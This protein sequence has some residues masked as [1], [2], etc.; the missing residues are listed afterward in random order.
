MYRNLLAL[1]ALIA[2]QAVALHAHAVTMCAAGNPDT[3]SV[4]EL[5]PT[6]AF[7]NHNDGTVTHS[8]TGLMWKQC[9]EGSSGAGCA[10]GAPAIMTWSAA[11]A[12]AVAD[13]TAGHSDW[14]LPNKKELES[15]VESCGFS[16][17]INQT[18]FPATPMSR[19][20]WSSSSWG[21]NPALAW[22]VDFGAGFSEGVTKSVE[23]YV[24]LVRGGQSFG[25]FD[26]NHAWQSAL[27]IDGNGTAD[28][29]TD[30]LLVIRYLFGLRGPP[31]IDRAIGTGA[32]RTT[33]PEIETY[34]K[35]LMP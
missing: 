1:A 17:T 26:A 5:T 22:R 4:A 25:S 13:T 3:T 35:N 6:S 31:L 29:L 7:V 30:G 8:L 18:L 27:D 16:P 33:A 21:P 14:R 23:Q 15:I 28:A 9:A 10:G 32:S 11:L 24:R 19:S 34:I 20:F 2:M 12:A